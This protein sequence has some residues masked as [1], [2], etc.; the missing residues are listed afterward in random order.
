VNTIPPQT[1]AAFND[2]GVL[3][4]R[5]RKDVPA[6][7]ALFARLPQLGV[8][9]DALV[10]QLEGEGVLAFAKSYDDLLAALEVRV[11]EMSPQRGASA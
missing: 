3:E 8:P 11:R 6:A 7:R 1:L 9:I 4:A 5:I 10:D 2:H